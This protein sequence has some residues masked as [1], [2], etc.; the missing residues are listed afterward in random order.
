MEYPRPKITVQEGKTDKDYEILSLEE[1]RD[2]R[3]MPDL[4]NQTLDNHLKRGTLDFTTIGR[5][6]Y[7]L[8]NDKAKTFSL[9]YSRPVQA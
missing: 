1:F 9:A 8:W 4:S 6:R 3:G 5:V 7:I 2:K